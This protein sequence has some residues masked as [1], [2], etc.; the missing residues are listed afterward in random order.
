[1]NSACR[2]ADRV[3]LH[4][5]LLSE[6]ESSFRQYGNPMAAPK[7]L[8]CEPQRRAI[9]W[10]KS[11]GQKRLASVGWQHEDD[12]KEGSDRYFVLQ[13]ERFVY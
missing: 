11:I 4:C 3:T 13:R 1:M 10:L 7:D 2:K 12:K 5:K 6:L 9:S 8:S